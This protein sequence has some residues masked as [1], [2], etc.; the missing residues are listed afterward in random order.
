MQTLIKSQDFLKN[1]QHS[2]PFDSSFVILKAQVSDLSKI[3]LFS[4]ATL[5]ILIHPLV[6]YSEYLENIQYIMTSSLEVGCWIVGTRNENL[7]FR[8]QIGWLI[9]IVDFYESNWSNF[10]QIRC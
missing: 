6:S 7:G 4:R 3:K 2:T 5:N 10:Q 1:C 8:A 9:Y